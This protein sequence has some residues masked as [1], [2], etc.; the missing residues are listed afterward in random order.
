[1]PA[2]VPGIRTISAKAIFFES[3]DAGTQDS[4]RGICPLE[5]CWT[6]V[7]QRDLFSRD[8]KT[9]AGAEKVLS[10]MKPWPDTRVRSWSYPLR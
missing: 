8:W 3:G 5:R 6:S 1:M 10:R 4:L 9:P 7:L 2:A